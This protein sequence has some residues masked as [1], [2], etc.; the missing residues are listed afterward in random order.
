MDADFMRAVVQFLK[1]VVH[2]KKAS[3]KNFEITLH[4]SCSF[5]HAYC[6]VSTMSEMKKGI[7]KKT[8]ITKLL[9]LYTAN[10]LSQRQDISV[11]GQ[12]GVVA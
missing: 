6:T 11:R 7:K 9:S 8:Q 3:S 2:P 12:H 10:L 4:H 5:S 1:K